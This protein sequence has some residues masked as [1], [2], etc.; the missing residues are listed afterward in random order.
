MYVLPAAKDSTHRPTQSNAKD[1]THFKICNS[2]ATDNGS[3]QSIRSL[4]QNI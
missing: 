1:K 4:P 3:I 2:K